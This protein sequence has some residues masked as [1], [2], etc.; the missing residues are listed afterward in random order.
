MAKKSLQGPSQLLVWMEPCR[1]V[2]K[3]LFVTF[4]S[5]GANLGSRLEIYW[6]HTLVLETCKVSSDLYLSFLCKE[7]FLF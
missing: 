2:R 1:I 6:S 7:F 4:K 5:G 3:L